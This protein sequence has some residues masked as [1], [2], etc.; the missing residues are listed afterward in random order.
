MTL[1]AQAPALLYQSTRFD[2]LSAISGRTY[3]IFVF[4]PASPPPSSGYPWCW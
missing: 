4:K 1:P 3:R 2:V